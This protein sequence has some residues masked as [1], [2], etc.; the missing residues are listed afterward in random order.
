MTLSYNVSRPPT[1]SPTHLA[2]ITAAIIGSTYCG[3]VEI[4]MQSGEGARAMGG[5]LAERRRKEKAQKRSRRGAS[6]RWAIAIEEGRGAD[7][8]AAA[9]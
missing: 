9:L 6:S 1:T 2:I 8:P 3:P 4:R 5:R 7:P